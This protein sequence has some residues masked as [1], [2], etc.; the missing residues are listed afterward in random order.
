MRP[1]LLQRLTDLLRAGDGDDAFHPIGATLEMLDRTVG[2]EDPARS[3][4]QLQ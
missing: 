3:A 1:Y 4:L 2:T